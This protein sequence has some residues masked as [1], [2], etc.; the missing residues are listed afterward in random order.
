MVSTSCKEKRWLPTA[1]STARFAVPAPPSAH[2]F[3]APPPLPRAAAEPHARS[4]PSRNKGFSI[5]RKNIRFEKPTLSLCRILTDFFRRLRPD[6]VFSP[7]K[8]GNFPPRN[9]GNEI[10]FNH[11]RSWPYFGTQIAYYI[12]QMRNLGRFPSGTKTE[13]EYQW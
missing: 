1:V 9:D 6:P 3:K 12:K 13:H 10:F 8:T 11:F 4:L 5:L 7:V 2:G